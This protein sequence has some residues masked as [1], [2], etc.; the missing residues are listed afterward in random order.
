MIIS[1]L[2]SCQRTIHFLLNQKAIKRIAT[3]LWPLLRWNLQYRGCAASL[4][5][6]WLAIFGNANLA[7]LCLMRTRGMKFQLREVSAS[8]AEI[9]TNKKR[10]TCNDASGQWFPSAKDPDQISA[11]SMRAPVHTS[12][13]GS[14][15]GGKHF[16]VLRRFQ[17]EVL[18]SLGHL[19]SGQGLE[20]T[21]NHVKSFPSCSARRSCIIY[22]DH[23]NPFFATIYT[24]NVVMYVSNYVFILVVLSWFIF[25]FPRF[26]Y[27]LMHLLVHSCVP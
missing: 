26:M 25:W 7:D 27:S 3:K 11:E 9:K 4:R 1:Y 22:T 23:M 18:N 6:T 19:G 15:V 24:C 5:K 12:Q 13:G 20:L 2:Q 10:S 14:T 16:N 21:W 8:V 17:E